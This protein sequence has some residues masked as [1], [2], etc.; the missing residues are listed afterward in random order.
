MNASTV[1]VTLLMG[2]DV[3]AGDWLTIDVAGPSPRWV[4]WGP[5]DER[6]GVAPRD[7][8]TGEELTLPSWYVTEA[9]GR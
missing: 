5:G 4:R 3:R 7:V 8:R 9:V 6:C 2:E 1:T